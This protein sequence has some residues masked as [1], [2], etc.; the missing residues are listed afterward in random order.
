MVGSTCAA[1]FEVDAAALPFTTEA[2]TSTARGHYG[3]FDGD[4]DGWVGKG[5]GSSDHAWRFAAPSAGTYRVTVVPDGWDAALYAVADC[6]DIAGS[7]LGAA[8][9]QN[10]ETLTLAMTAGEEV[11]LIV[12]GVTNAVNTA[13][14]YRLTVEALP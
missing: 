4:C 6:A 5:L 14:P 13:G 10:E 1:P 12:D 11:F 3:F 8:D 7:C 2:D 9:G